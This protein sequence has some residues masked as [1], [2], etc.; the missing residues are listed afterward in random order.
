MAS[1]VTRTLRP[2]T[3]SENSRPSSRCPSNRR[4]RARAGDREIPGRRQRPHIVAD[5]RRPVAL[6]DDVG[7]RLQRLAAPRDGDADF[8]QSQELV[9]VFRVANRDGVA[10]REPQRLERDVQSGR[11]AHALRQRSSHARG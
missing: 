10:G 8:S 2:R 6:E 3:A 1:P 5:G 9:I 4:R 11:L 7:G